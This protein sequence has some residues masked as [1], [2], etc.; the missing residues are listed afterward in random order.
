MKKSLLFFFS[1][2]LTQ[3]LMSQELAV[4]ATAT[5]SISS[6]S[7]LNMG[8]LEM[9]PSAVYSIVDNAITHSGTPLSIN[10]NPAIERVYSSINALNN[11]VGE[12]TI[13]Y[14][15]GELNGLDEGALIIRYLRR[16]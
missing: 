11:Y 8:G 4:S 14:E 6:S 10:G 13:H 3:H 16:F 7:S 1:L 9:A 12:I 5:V 15:Q 2:I